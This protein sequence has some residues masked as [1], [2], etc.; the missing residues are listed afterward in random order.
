MKLPQKTTAG[1]L[2]KREKNHA[3]FRGLCSRL[4]SWIF[5]VAFEKQERGIRGQSV[6][7]RID[8]ARK[9][10]DGSNAG[11]DCV[12]DGNE[13]SLHSDDPQR[14]PHNFQRAFKGRYGAHS[15][16]TFAAPL[17]FNFLSQPTPRN[18]VAILLCLCACLFLAPAVRA[19]TARVNV[20]I[21]FDDAA[22]QGPITGIKVEPISPPWSESP[23]VVLGD[24]ITRASKT[25]PV[26]ITNLFGSDDTNTA[27]YRVTIS[28][29]VPT[30]YYF[31][32][33]LTNGNAADLSIAAPGQ[34][35]SWAAGFFAPRSLLS[36]AVQRISTNGVP[37]FTGGVTNVDFITGVTGYVSGATV[38]LGVTATSG[39]GS[40]DAGGTNAR[41][42]GTLNL[43]NWSNIPTGEMANVP[44]VTFLTNS[45]TS[46]QSTQA[47]LVSGSNAI[48]GKLDSNVW[49]NSWGALSTNAL[50]GKLASNS[51]LGNLAAGAALTNSGQFVASLNG[52]A[53]NLQAFGLTGA[54]ND[55]FRV[56]NTNGAVVT[57]IQTNK[58]LFHDGAITNSGA[59]DVAGN[60][61]TYGNLSVMN[62]LSTGSGNLT[63]GGNENISATATN[64]LMRS[65][66]VQINALLGAAIAY[67]HVSNAPGSV[68]LPLAIIGTNN[69]GNGLTVSTN[70]QV[71]IGT[72]SPIMTL[73]VN[74]HVNLRSNVTASTLGSNTSPV[75]YLGQDATGRVWQVA[76]PTSSGSSGPT[77]N[78][79]PYAIAINSALG[80]TNILVDMLALGPTNHVRATLTANAGIMFTNVIDGMAI[81]LEL[82]QD[83]TGNRTVST[84][85]TWG[86]NVRFGIDVTGFG[87][88]TNASTKDIV[89]FIGS[90][91]NVL[92]AGN[93]RGFSL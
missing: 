35:A 68:N 12:A 44:A 28:S 74:G 43:T 89:R 65:G 78:A 70:G 52:N 39:G 82:I 93:L 83:S 81:T 88:S 8:H 5:H 62:F 38:H 45:I 32:A 36:N 55:L 54:T 60:F 34:S 48:T 33:W 24:P 79:P 47:A 37:M 72:T 6:S 87:Q 71:G 20:T 73:D 51:I 22:Q 86:F 91:T 75:N 17:R 53:T 77:T 4:R 50:T 21:A 31:K 46:I 15:S 90:G 10:H 14:V 2:T 3:R 41:Q 13:C 57:E 9:N 11:G 29:K 66:A 92:V 56:N 18:A 84:N 85:A 67:L 49:Q 16:A 59:L 1:R 61:K 19:A 58:T 30:V 80:S 26:I 69:T 27:V 42:F 63:V 76:A 23:G 40:G 64:N 7:Q 25:S